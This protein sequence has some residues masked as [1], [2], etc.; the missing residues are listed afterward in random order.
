MTGT[1]DLLLFFVSVVLLN[2]TPGPDSLLVTSRTASMGVAAGIQASVGVTLGSFV[3]VLAATFG[4]SVIIA[5]SATAFTVIKV[6]GAAYLIY[7]GLT[8]IF[9]RSN[10]AMANQAGE[11]TAQPNA[12]NTAPR[13][14][15]LILQ[16]FL[17]NALNPKVALFFLAFVPQFVDTNSTNPTLAFLLLGS[18][19]SAMTL[20]NGFAM[21]GLSAWA[22]QRIRLSAEVNDKINKGIGALFVGFG[23][24]L[25]LTSKD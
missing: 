16:G 4:L 1:H 10:K 22:K 19:F 7:M 25:A 12:V 8:A 6:L 21:V 13:R 23:V 14:R 11:T 2:L 24:K 9:S 15:N 3:H 18:I 5:N 20:L 17:S